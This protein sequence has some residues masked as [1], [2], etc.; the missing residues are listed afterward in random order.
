MTQSTATNGLMGI[1]IDWN[2]GSM[3]PSLVVDSSL[4][5]NG[6]D[7]NHTSMAKNGATPSWLMN[8]VR[9]RF[10]SRSSVDTRLHFAQLDFATDWTGLFA[11]IRFD[12]ITS[13]MALH[14]ADDKQQLF[15]QVYS[16]LKPNGVFVLAD[17]MAGASACIQYLF[18]R[19]RALVR[20][21]RDGKENPE[22]VL[23]LISGDEERGRA[24]GNVCET[25]VQYERYLDQSGFED[26]DCIWRDYWL[27]V[28]PNHRIQRTAPRLPLMPMPCV[29][30]H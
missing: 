18:A 11:G 10:A 23:E 28:S 24:E 4:R 5:L 20:L 9:S 2:A 25:V 27:R 14:H 8:C 29:K 15:Q 21:R 6:R 7:V 26:V 12:A 22:R 30:T 13:S 19:E 3:D 1:T 16:A 17:H